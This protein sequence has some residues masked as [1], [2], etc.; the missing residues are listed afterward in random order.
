M[1]VNTSKLS[2]PLQEVKTFTLFPQF[3]S[4]IRLKIWKLALSEPRMSMIEQKIPPHR[5]RFIFRSRL[6]PPTLLHVNYESR[7]LAQKVYE[8][9][10]EGGLEAPQFFNFQ[11]D[12]LHLQLRT[13]A[14]DWSKNFETIQKDFAKVQHLVIYGG[15]FFILPISKL[16]KNLVLFKEL[17][18]HYGANEDENVR[19]PGKLEEMWDIIRREVEAVENLLFKSLSS[20]S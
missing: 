4:E 20:N 19:I 16:K 14:S 12:S 13:H 15:F 2:D 7:S 3:P 17:I 6:A 8:L 1:G 10:F 5:N 11:V 18:I 9:T